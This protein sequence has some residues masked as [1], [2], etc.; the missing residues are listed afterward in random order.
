MTPWT[1]ACLAPLSMGFPRQ[2]YWSRLPFVSP[3]DLPGD[4]RIKLTSS[5]W[6]VDSLPLICLGNPQY[7]VGYIKTGEIY[8]LDSQSGTGFPNHNNTTDIWGKV[9]ICC[10]AVLCIVG[11]LAASLASTHQ[12]P[13]AFCLSCAIKMLWQPKMSPNIAKCPLERSRQNFTARWKP[14]I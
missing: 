3:G 5:T 6:Q 13:V 2:E 11:Y 12:M 8:L 7:K 4:P 10:A 9:I 14:L 1:V